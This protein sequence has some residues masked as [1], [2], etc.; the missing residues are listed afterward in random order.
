MIKNILGILGTWLMYIS[1]HIGHQEYFTGLSLLDWD[2]RISQCMAILG[3]LPL[4]ECRHLLPLGRIDGRVNRDVRLQHAGPTTACT[5][6][7]NATSM[8][9]YGIFLPPD[10]SSRLNFLR[11]RMCRSLGWSKFSL[12]Q[13]TC[14][15]YDDAL[16]KEA[17]KHGC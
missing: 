8:S 15:P 6:G 16:A 13:P 11:I 2:W 5:F 4:R 7:T 3:S 1:I 17:T 9:F 12:H 10:P 14:V